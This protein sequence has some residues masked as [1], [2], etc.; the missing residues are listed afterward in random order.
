MQ[1]SLFDLGFAGFLLLFGDCEFD[2]TFLLRRAVYSLLSSNVF[3]EGLQFEFNFLSE[4]ILS[5]NVLK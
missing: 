2:G 4:E 5:G 1:E 3:N